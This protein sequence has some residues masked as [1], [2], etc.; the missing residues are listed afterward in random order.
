[1]AVSSL[2]ILPEH[3]IIDLYKDTPAAVP[4]IVKGQ[5]QLQLTRPIHVRQITVIFRGQVRS[6][7]SNDYTQ[8][9]AGLS[10]A[11]QTIVR[12]EQLLLNERTIVTGGLTRWP[13]EISIRGAHQLPPSVDLSRHTILYEVSARLSLSSLTERLKLNWNERINSLGLSRSSLDP[14]PVTHSMDNNV[15]SDWL[16]VA[17]PPRKQKRALMRVSRSIQVLNHS[18]ASLDVA[19]RSRPRIRYR[20]KRQ[21]IT[22][23]RPSSENCHVHRA[24]RNLPV[25][26]SLCVHFFF[27][28]S[29]KPIT[30]LMYILLFLYSV[31]VPV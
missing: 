5:V 11:S 30:D 1:M 16:S 24:G 22:R 28:F 2:S 4:L 10:T 26:H 13:F 31:S 21:A 6:E 15:N 3:T 17:L 14:D 12:E 25:S 29:T 7:I 18:Y 19:R 8:I 27:E 20:G 9:V 23:R